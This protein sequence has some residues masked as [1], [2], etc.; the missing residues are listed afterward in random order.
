METII[1]GAVFG[2]LLG[3]CL[4]GVFDMEKQIRKLK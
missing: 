4:F 1:I 3:I 2:L